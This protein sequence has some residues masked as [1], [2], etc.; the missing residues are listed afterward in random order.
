MNEQLKPSV[1]QN[2]A[3][4]L[5]ECELGIARWNAKIK[6]ARVNDDYKGIYKLLKDA[7]FKIP[8]KSIPQNWKSKYE[9][10][11]LSGKEPLDFLLH[12]YIAYSPNKNSK[13]DPSDLKLVVIDM[14]TDTKQLLYDN[15]NAILVSKPAQSI[16]L[17][18]SKAKQ[19][20][21]DNDI[22]LP[23]ADERICDWQT[24][25]KK[26]TKKTIEFEPL[27]LFFRGFSIPYADFDDLSKE[28]TDH[29][30]GFLGL[31]QRNGEKPLNLKFVE[32]IFA[33]L[34]VKKTAD[35]NNEISVSAENASLPIPPFKP[36]EDF[37][38][39]ETSGGYV[40]AP[41]L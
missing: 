2:P 12:A 27:D 38:L 33:T 8:V 6:E 32:I 4:N 30:H 35:N 3:I 20:V 40:A 36:G 15:T 11:L 14:L 13:D 10:W 23:E 39:F 18:C 1:G 25:G 5:S 26:W 21:R 19:N 28:D 9:L 22:S 29:L 17:Q 7:A 16:P 37:S 41:E 34:S 31:R 24:N